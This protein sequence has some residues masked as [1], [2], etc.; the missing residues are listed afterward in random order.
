M[1]RHTNFSI[2][3]IKTLEFHGKIIGFHIT[4]IGFELPFETQ[5]TLGEHD[6]NNCESCKGILT[7]LKNRLTDKYEG[8]QANKLPFPFCCP[9]HSKLTADKRFSKQDF[10][11]KNIPLLVA[12]KIIYTKQHILNKQSCEDWYEDIT[13]YIDYTVSSFGKMP[14]GAF[15]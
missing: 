13:D 4:G 3:E 5:P 12:S 1:N 11:S 14:E 6:F 7:E 2:K 10:D 8:K 15:I 9:Q